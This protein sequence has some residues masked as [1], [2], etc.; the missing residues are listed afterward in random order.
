[1]DDLIAQSTS[2][3][4]VVVNMKESESGRRSRANKCVYSSTLF[5]PHTLLRLIVVAGESGLQRAT[6]QSLNNMVRKEI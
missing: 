3:A 6:M 1:M 5:S 2:A 4:A